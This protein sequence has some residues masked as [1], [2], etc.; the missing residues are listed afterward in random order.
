MAINNR[1]SPAS[2]LMSDALRLPSSLSACLFAA[3][4]FMSPLSGVRPIPSLSYGDLLFAISCACALAERLANREQIYFFWI[5]LLAALLITSSYL[6]NQF[7]SHGMTAYE[8]GQFISACLDN[9]VEIVLSQ[10]PNFRTLFTSLIIF[11]QAFLLQRPRSYG[12]VRCLIYIWTMGAIYGAAFT[13]AYCIGLFDWSDDYFW[14][15][16]HRARGLT[17]HPNAMALSTVLAFPG[18]LLLFF[19]SRNTLLRLAVLVAVFIAWRAIGYSGSRTAIYTLMAMAAIV[20]ALLYQQVPAYF[21]V[22][23]IAATALIATGYIIFKYAMGPSDHNSALWRLENGS[24]TSDTIRAN[25]HEIATTG[26][27]NSPIFGQGFQWLRIAHNMYL[28][29]LHSS[30]LAGFLGFAL[31]MSYPFYLTLVFWQSINSLS[32]RILRSCLLTGALGVLVWGWAQPN[33]NALN[34]TVPFGLLLCLSIIVRAKQ[35]RTRAGRLPDSSELL[36]RL[37]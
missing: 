15:V 12:E 19:E 27:E 28:Q 35:L 4:L 1:I 8:Y 7:A 34:P 26:F 18:L 36:P 2:G 6:V 9:H 16:L 23:L 33:I 14:R 24:A 10:N 21:R 37:S 3:A 25:D 30:G 11:P 5:Y 13:V 32:Q 29:M 20:F 31:A 17:G 22:R